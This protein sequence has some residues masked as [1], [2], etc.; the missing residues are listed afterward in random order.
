[1]RRCRLEK[2]RLFGEWSWGLG[3]EPWLTT[4]DG[5][6]QDE[7]K[8]PVRR[9]GRIRH[10]DVKAWNFSGIASFVKILVLVVDTPEKQ[11]AEFVETHLVG[12]GIG[13]THLVGQLWCVLTDFKP[14]AKNITVRCLE[15]R[16]MKK[17][18]VADLKHKQSLSSTLEAQPR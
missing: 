9:K 17:S 8:V 13:D 5:K 10:Q 6:V 2:S 14:A 18:Q 3:H 7:R 16:L 1:M 11:S 15:T 4:F 12:I